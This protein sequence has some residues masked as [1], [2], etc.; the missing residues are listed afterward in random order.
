MAAGEDPVLAYLVRLS[1]T[2][3]SLLHWHMAKFLLT[4]SPAAHNSKA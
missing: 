2:P 4:F 3:A 1:I